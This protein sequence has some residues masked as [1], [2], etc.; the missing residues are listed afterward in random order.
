VIS[1]L[2]SLVALVSPISIR[3]TEY[4][5]RIG[6][7]AQEDI[8]APRTMSFVSEVHTEQARLEAEHNV[9]PIFNA[10]DPAIARKQIEKLRISLNYISAVRADTYAN[11]QNKI[12]DLKAVKDIRV[13]EDMANRILA[14]SSERWETIQA[15]ALNVLEQVMRNTIRE[16]RV[17]D[18]QRNVPTLVSFSLSQDQVQIVSEL[19]IPFVTPNSLYNEEQTQVSRQAARDSISP[20][21]RKYIAG[22]SIVQRGQII[23]PAIWESLSQFGLVSPQGYSENL[24]AST[25][26]VSLLCVLFYLFLTQTKSPILADSRSLLLI[27]ISFLAFLFASR[28]LIPNRTVLP[29]LFPVSAL[30]MALASL[31][32]IGLGMVITLLL[33]ILAAYGL[34]YSLDLTLFYVLATFFGIFV[35]GKGRRIAHFFWA[36]VAIFGAGSAVILAYRLPGFVTDWIGIGTLI[37]AALFNGMA[38]A[39]LSLLLQFLLSQVLG[40]TTSMELLEISRPDHPLL[41]FI[42]QNA[43]GTYQHSLMVANLGEQAAKAVGADAL[44][45]RVGSLHHDAGKAL[46]PS[47]F[48]ENQVHGNLNPHDDLDP[49]LSSATIIRHVTDGVQ[50]AQKYRLPPRIQDFIREHHGTL[51]TRYQYSQAVKTA[52]GDS[53]QV[54]EDDFR[55]PG[56]RPQSRETGIIMLAD[57]VEARAR[58]ELPRNDTEISSLV[59]SSFEFIKQSGQLD[60][61]NLTLRDLNLIAESFVNTLRNTYHPRIKYPEIKLNQSATKISADASSQS[62]TIPVS[63]KSEIDGPYR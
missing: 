24:A 2:L 27:S 31:F 53:S 55:Y 13:N 35:L 14:L 19:V 5:I 16:D 49:I 63:E 58:A 47:F 59:K 8:Q 52:G 29:Y 57:G 32:N 25:A 17:Y 50:L 38:S 51:I 40:K 54:N 23:T 61:T 7:V 26:L 62:I 21:T 46:N 11:Y 12:S 56:P 10:A 18:F 60:D 34:P 44:L 1:G 41:Q 4:S 22:E 28:L 6:E 9:A 45:I 37:G 3:Q 43:P 20:V 36:G 15:E 33:S 42:L 48:I 39:S 30:G